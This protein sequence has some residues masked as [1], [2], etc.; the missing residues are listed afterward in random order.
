[1]D[2]DI[3]IR[4]IEQVPHFE[5]L[6]KVETNYVLLA[7]ENYLETHGYVEKPS[8]LTDHIIL[9]YGPSAFSGIDLNWHLQGKKYNLPPLSSKFMISS[10]SG[11]FKATPLDMGI[12]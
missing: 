8:D 9:A 6:W 11:L 5:L 10:T 7:S 1:S 4:P 3:V 2:Y 12:S